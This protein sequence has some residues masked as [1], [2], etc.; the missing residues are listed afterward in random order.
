MLKPLAPPMKTQQGVTLIESLVSIL[1]LAIGL[2]GLAGLQGK[3]TLAEAESYQRAQALLLL[4]DMAERIS[5]NRPNAGDY[6]VSSLGTGTADADCTAIA[7]RADR[8]L[9]EWNLLLKGAAE[10]KSGSKVGAM[11][12]ARGC[13]TRTQAPDPTP[14]VCIPGI[15]KITV[16]WQG[17]HQ[18]VAPAA[19]VTCGEGLYGDETTRRAISTQVQIGLPNCS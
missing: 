4:S 8:D 15:Y 3:L 11:I 10:K 13:I 16:V 14:A 17:I 6:Q 7:A 1:I 19:S 2:L 9:C 5:A 18:T 12:D